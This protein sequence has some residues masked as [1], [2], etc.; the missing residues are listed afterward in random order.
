M[1]T[2]FRLPNKLGV[3]CPGK[4]KSDSVG[5]DDFLANVFQQVFI[6]LGFY[7][8]QFCCNFS[9]SAKSKSIS[10][11]VRKKNWI[12]PTRGSSLIVGVRTILALPDTCTFLMGGN[13]I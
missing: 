4:G 10:G 7:C 3:S 5:E 2:T 9:C 11:F 12:P 8:R 6:D 1:P 13:G